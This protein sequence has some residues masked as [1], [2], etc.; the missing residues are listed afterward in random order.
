M[1]RERVPGERSG[2][3]RQGPGPSLARDRCASRAGSLSISGGI[4]NV[5]EKTPVSRGSVSEIATLQEAY[6]SFITRAI[7]VDIR[8]H[9]LASIASCRRPDAV[10]R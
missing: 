7:A 2:D 9:S 6:A 5:S 8:S 4:A 1:S 3:S 10:S